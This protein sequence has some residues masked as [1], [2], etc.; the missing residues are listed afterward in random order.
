MKNDK[1][2]FATIAIDTDN[3]G[4]GDFAQSQSGTR[5]KDV[6]LAL[7]KKLKIIINSKSGYKAFLTSESNKFLGV[8]ERVAIARKHQAHLLISLH[9]DAFTNSFVKGASVYALSLN[10]ANSEV[11]RLIAEKENSSDLIGGVSLDDKDD[12]IASVLLDLSLT[13]TIQDSLEL[14]ANI[15]RHLGKFLKL[16][17]RQVQQANLEILKAPDMPSVYVNI[18]NLS[19]PDDELNHRTSGQLQ[20]IATSIFTAIQEHLI[21]SAIKWHLRDQIR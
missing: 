15:L 4:M 9:V 8:R 19:N 6:T 5:E 1:K 7:A 18:D 16:K 14:G 10:G 13:A 2:L 3:G 11:A 17:E 20:N 12:L 21:F